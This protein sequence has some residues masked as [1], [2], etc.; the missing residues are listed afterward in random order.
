MAIPDYIKAVRDGDYEHGLKL[1]YDS[2]PF[3]QICGKVC[4]RRCETTCAAS[5]EGDPIAIE[6]GAGAT[7]GR[8]AKLY[9]QIENGRVVADVGWGVCLA[10]V[11][12]ACAFLVARR[13]R[14]SA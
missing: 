10:T 1:L 7:E 8:L 6:T 4:T 12:V 9:P 3:S 2:N 5:H 11:T 13:G 14:R